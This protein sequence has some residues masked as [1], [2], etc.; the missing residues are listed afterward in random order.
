MAKYT[1]GKFYKAYT[2]EDLIKIFRDIYNSLRQYY[3]ITYTPPT[4]W[5][6]HTVYSELTIPGRDSV[7]IAQAEYGTDDIFPW[8]DLES[9]FKRPI[10]FEFN[11]DSLLAGSFP[12]MDEI[13]DVMMSRPSLRLEVQGHTDNV[14]TR[15]FNQIL[16]EGRARN[17]MDAL[18]ER[19]IE[20][21]RL[22]YRG[23]GFSQPIASNDT[24]Q[25]RTQNRRTVFLITAK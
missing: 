5:G 10:L 23:F 21:R 16:S 25:G 20:Q 24:E 17:V 14:G 3:L 6:T 4:F 2:K 8:S 15:E 1:G 9:T 11:S 19:G 7:L 18:I 13:V 22:R 12:I